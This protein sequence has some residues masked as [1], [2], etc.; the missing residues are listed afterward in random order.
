MPTRVLFFLLF[1]QLSF[2]QLSNFTLIVN[3]TDQTCPANGTLSFNVSNTTAG[4]TILYTIYLLPNVTLPITVTSANNFGGLI[5]GIYRVVATQ[6]LGANSESQQQDVVILNQITSLNYQVSVVNEVCGSDGKITVSIISGNPVSYEIFSGPM[7]LPLQ[8]S[9]I[10]NNLSAGQYQVRVFDACGEGVVQTVTVSAVSPAL[11]FDLSDPYF[12][13]CTTIKIGFAFSSLSQAPLGVIKFPL[14]VHTTVTYSSSTIQTYD[15]TISTGGNFSLSIPAGSTQPYTYSFSITDGC[16]IVYNLNGTVQALLPTINYVLQPQDCSHKILVIDNVSALILT[17]APAGFSAT[18]PQ[19]YTSQ[20]VNNSIIIQ[21]LIAGTYTFNAIDICGNPQT[22]TVTVVILSN[23]TPYYIFFNRTCSSSTIGIYNVQQVVLISAPTSYPNTLP[24]SYTNLINSVNFV[25]ILNQPLGTYVFQV[26]DTCGIASIMTVTIEPFISTPTFQVLQSC[27]E[28]FGTIKINGQFSSMVITAAPS[29]YPHTLPYDVSSNIILSNTVFTINGL[30]AG[31][32]TFQSVDS[33]GTISNSDVSIVGFQQTTSITVLPHCGSFD[34][35]LIHTSNNSSSNG[36][37]LQKYN[38]ISNNWVHPGNGNIYNPGLNPNIGNS[39]PLTNNVINY[40]LAFT[41]VFRIIKTQTVYSNAVSSSNLCNTIISEFE[42]DDKPKINQIYSISCGQTF[43]VIVDAVG[44][45]QLIYR[46]TT[47]DG[48]PFIIQNGTSSIF[49]NLQPGTY[50]FQVEDVCGN[51]LNSLFQVINPNPLQITS[52]SLCNGENASLSVPNFPFLQYQWWK[53]NT[54]S[55]ILSTSNSLL[56][57][58]FNVSSNNGVY[59]VSIT[60][61]ENPNSCLNQVLNYT[62]SI[63][64]NNPNAGL[65]TSISYCGYQ[66]VIDLFSLLN[67]AFDVNGSWSEITNSNTLNGNNWNSNTVAFGTYQFIYRVDGLCDLFDESTVSITINEIPE[68]PIVTSDAIVCNN[69]D[70]NLY[71]SSVSNVSY[72]WSGPNNFSSSE[73]NPIIENASEINN[74][75][76][77]VSISNGTCESEFS[78]VEVMINSN[79]D[80]DLS[81]SC[82]GA[83]LIVK[84]AVSGNSYDQF[85][86]SFSWIGP[87]NFTSF[88]PEITITN[89][90]IGDY[91]LTVT[92]ENGCS[93]SKSIAVPRT[94]CAIPNV[95]TPNADATN[96][97]FNLQGFDVDKIKIYNRWGRIVYDKANYTNEWYGQNNSG[98][99]LPEGTYFYLLNFRTGENKQGWIFVAR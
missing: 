37:W 20:I 34:I 27:Q 26:V 57:S 8:S 46:I 2:G 71:A 81:W 17:S 23:V 53:D 67:G 58:P 59:H 52:S 85:T 6:S 69:Q 28:G 15:N 16:G 95:I 91:Q 61:S 63:S 66:G 3:H 80:F 99:L 38:P 4:S 96:E 72:S 25:A 89:L 86:A 84:S 29:S 94:I 30:P 97:N 70:L 82:T 73:Q 7:V 32:Y 88:N 76:Y 39:I 68:T 92:N 83:N 5:D 35:E 18:L 11:N 75:I 43:E 36:F 40:N 60:Y 45:S 56:F 79:P 78:L 21:N 77:T 9:N 48:Q 65:D 49:T 64:S 44:I 22:I 87:N 50:N 19:N 55:T 24:Y 74:G 12:E 10:F 33:C 1:T 13:N 54:T 31:M 41:G 51:I 47:K 90:E 98:E 42:F 14:Q 62:I 93:V